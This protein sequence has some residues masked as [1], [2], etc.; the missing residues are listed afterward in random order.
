MNQRS[1]F[2]KSERRMRYLA[3]ACCCTAVLVACQKPERGA[4]GDSTA[5][6]SAAAP[7]TPAAPALSA[8]DV[9]GKWNVLAKNAAG[10]SVLTTFVLTATASTAGWTITFP[11]RAPIPAGVSIEGDS[12]IIDAGPYPSVL[13]KGVMVTTHNVS[14]LQGGK[15]V[16]ESVAHYATHKPDSVSRHPTEGTRA[17]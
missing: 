13:R 2:P 14:R 5:V 12:I 9:A 4:H 10:D 6:V 3:I 8:A 17:P 15:L 11:K 16:G 1:N 7:A